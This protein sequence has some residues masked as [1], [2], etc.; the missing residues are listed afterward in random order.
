MKTETEFFGGTGITLEKLSDTLGKMNVDGTYYTVQK[1]LKECK[2]FD[3]L[4]PN[5]SKVWIPYSLWEQGMV[6]EVIWEKYNFCNYSFPIEMN[7]WWIYIP[8]CKVQHATGTWF[9][10]EI[11]YYIKNVRRKT[12][13]KE[14]I[15]RKSE[16]ARKF[17]SKLDIAEFKKNEAIANSK[18]KRNSI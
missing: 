4:I 9:V 7:D 15:R 16:P 3:S 2:V 6:V 17:L 12:Q 13:I 11:T 10:Y 5:K 1:W 8:Y 18:R 14:L